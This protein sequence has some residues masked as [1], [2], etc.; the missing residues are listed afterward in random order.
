[1]IRLFSNTEQPQQ[2]HQ[3]L[4]QYKRKRLLTYKRDNIQRWVYTL[5]F[6]TKSLVNQVLN[7]EQKQLLACF[8]FAYY[9]LYGSCFECFTFWLKMQL[10]CVSS[11]QTPQRSVIPSRAS[12]QTPCTSLLSWLPKVGSPV[13]GAWRHT[14]QLMKQ[15]SLSDRLSYHLVMPS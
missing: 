15:V 5:L 3:H 1:M 14:P 9:G 10:Y 8:T 13:P 2:Y 12:N 6:I 7:S 4:K 11:L